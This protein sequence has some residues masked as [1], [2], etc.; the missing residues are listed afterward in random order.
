MSAPLN[1]VA[2]FGFSKDEDEP[3][4]LLTNHAVADKESCLN[5][6]KAYL[7]RWKIEEYFKFKKQVFSFEKMRISK[8]AALKNLNVFLTIVLGFIAV[9]SLSQIA[10]KLIFLSEPIRKKV[11]F[12]YYRLHAGL[13]VLSHNFNDVLQ[14][15][16]P[17]KT[18]LFIPRQRDIFYY[19]RYQKNRRNLRPFQNGET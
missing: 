8:L 2:V 18:R 10:K 17:P 5:I 13:R 15:V 12:L 11:A 3:F 19:L 1:L 16:T 9:L 6:V 4:F 7:S 14:A